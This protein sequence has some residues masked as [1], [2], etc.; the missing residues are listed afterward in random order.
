MGH[1]VLSNI[2]PLVPCHGYIL[3]PPKGPILENNLKNL[4]KKLK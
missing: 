4:A 1:D 2:N 3:G